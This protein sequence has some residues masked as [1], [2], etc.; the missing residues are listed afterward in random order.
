MVFAVAVVVIDI[1]EEQTAGQPVPLDIVGQLV[2]RGIG[3]IGKGKRRDVAGFQVVRH[4][5]AGGDRPLL[6]RRAPPTSCVT[7]KSRKLSLP[8]LVRAI[9]PST[10]PGRS[11]M[12]K[13]TRVSI[14]LSALFSKT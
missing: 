12:G 11:G 3:A 7:V 8:E 1:V 5:D 14:S 13:A 10:W 4:V 9:S 2:Q 6:Q